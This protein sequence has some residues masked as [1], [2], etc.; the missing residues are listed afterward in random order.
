M[1][2][3]L[4]LI[5]ISAR[6]RRRQNRLTILCIVTAVF[7]VTAIFSVA[8]M[9]LRTQ[10]G[11]AA[12]K[13]G[14]WHLEVTGIT[15][16]QA[17]QLV[18]QPDVVRVGAGAV[19]NENGESAYR[20][21]GK[22]GVLYGADADYVSLN[23]AAAFAGTY[24]QAE[25]EVLLGKTA[26]RVLHVGSGDT[27]TLTLP[28]GT[29]KPLTVT[30][31]GGIDENFYGEQYS[32]VDAY[33]PQEAFAALL[34]AN[35]E[36]LPQTH[37]ELEYTSAARAAKA[38]PKL[39]SR[40]G[41]TAVQENL[42]VMGSAGQ[43]SSTA[44]QTVYGM[45]AVLFVLVLLA[46]VLMISGSMNSNLAQRTQFF[47]MM[48]CI[49][50]S[51]RQ[52]IRFVRLE[53]LNWCRTAV[54][55][56]LVLGTLASWTICAA[57]RYGIGGEFAATPVWQLS[58]AGLCAGAVVGMVTVLLAAQAPAKR[59]AK[60][61]PMAA[62]S[63]STQNVPVGRAAHAGKGRVELALGVRHATA[64]K[65]N[66][67][68]MTASFALSI[69][70]ALGFTVLLQFASLLLPS[71][72]PWQPDVLY[73]GYGNAQVLPGSMTRTLLEVPGVAHA[74]GCT[75]L[76]DTPA[77]SD[78]G[79]VDHVIFCSY[80]D[81]MLE[82]SRSVVVRGR[83]PGAGNEVMTIYNKNNPMQIGDVIT[84]NGVPL[85][86]VGAFSEGTFP[87]DVTLIAPEALFRQ[88]AGDQNYNMVGVQLDRTADEDTLFTLADL[89]TDDVI[90]QDLRE[91]N[92]QDRG[93]YYAV[94][95]VLYGFLAIIGGI[96]LLNI[97]N[98]IP[99][100]VSARAR[101]YG[102][103]RA[104]GMEDVQLC[105]M[106]AAEA[107]TYAASGLLVGVAAGLV[108]HRALYTRLITHYFGVV[109]RVP[110]GLLAVLCL[111]VAGAAALAVHGPVKR[112]QAMPVTA[113]INEL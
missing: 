57:L 70:L 113:A 45:A 67:A 34:T 40:Y 29:E 65:K 41:E 55:I 49:G 100:S 28:D 32:I 44:F 58:P 7:L 31:V 91:S 33:L 20:L 9:M 109:W 69:V 107:G 4:S 43:S 90:M 13:S 94:R 78:K 66:W 75:G 15:P 19:F 68:L 30:G 96:S 112:L 3:Y 37:Y 5:P 72:V 76:V 73:N 50:M 46:G 52:V 79:N 83:M 93:T 35:G 61:S 18:G 59:A 26:A 102:A 16:E 64:S 110:F 42:Q 6:V 101:Q 74:W 27:V 25:N 86:I 51:K 87:D 95:I 11:R 56:G 103:M 98:S 14:S 111:F 47:G 63:G 71:L 108:L 53:A 104:V 60:V 24:P 92:R 106:I 54:P 17:A 97:V 81:Y 80:D 62:V 23:R 1:K 21:N 105:R 2:S 77:S 48:R 38:L 12:G 99:M 39:R 82:S 85:T 84:V 88:V 8:D 89:A 10:T 36:A 22:R